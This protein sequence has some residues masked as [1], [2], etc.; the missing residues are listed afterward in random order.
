MEEVRSN[1]DVVYRCIYHVVWCPKYR[2]PVITGPVD[3][4]L[5]QIIVQVC[6]ERDAPIV[7]L[8]I[9]PDHVQLLVTV[10]PQFGIH[11]LVKAIKSRSSRLLRQEFPTLKTRLPTLWTNSYFVATIGGATSEAVNRYVQNQRNA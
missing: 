10:D 6:A 8:E 5:K 2:R 7:E 3:A 11:R 1:N 4:R 9:M